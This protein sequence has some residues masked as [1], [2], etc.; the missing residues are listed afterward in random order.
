M[1]DGEGAAA[2]GLADELVADGAALKRALELALAICRKASP[3]AL[4]ATKRLLND[5][6][7]MPWR[8]ALS[9]AAEANARQRL[10]P[11]CRRGVRAFLEA[12]TT[13][14]WLDEE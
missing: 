4:E 13:P 3:S 2:V 6:V 1:L 11:E 9:F 8:Q 12:K 14:D 7:G 10:H 5:T